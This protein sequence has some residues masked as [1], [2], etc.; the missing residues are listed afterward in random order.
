MRLTGIRKIS[1]VDLKLI[2]KSSEHHLQHGLGEFQCL[3][4][5]K[6]GILHGGLG[7][8]RCPGKRVKDGDK[9]FCFVYQDKYYPKDYAADILKRAKRELARRK[10]R[11]KKK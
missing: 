6:Y 3:L 9:S 5:K 2:I 4:C 8:G 7:C 11:D 1:M 10:R